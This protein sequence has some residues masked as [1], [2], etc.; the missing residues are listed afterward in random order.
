MEVIS[1]V[2]HLRSESERLVRLG[3]L[4]WCRPMA[5]DWREAPQVTL[6]PSKQYRS[7]CEFILIDPN[8]PYSISSRNRM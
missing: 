6:K 2:A 1:L 4:G 5:Q 3:T 8:L 7:G